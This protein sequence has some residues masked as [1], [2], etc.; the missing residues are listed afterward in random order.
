MT[1]AVL[2]CPTTKLSLA[3]VPLAAARAAIGVETLASRPP[4]EGFNATPFGET[5]TVLLRS[6]N[7]AAY[8]VL[9]D[10]IPVLFAPEVL[11]RSDS[12]PSFDLRDVRYAEAYEEMDHYNAIGQKLARLVADGQM[13]AL[14]SQDGFGL[15]QLG[16]IP[17]RMAGIAKGQKFP[18]PFNT[19][20]A[21][22]ADVA[23]EIDCY[24]H[25]A[26]VEGKRILQ[27]GGAAD[28]ILRLLLAGARDGVLLTPMVGEALVSMEL[29][30]I[31]G[32]SDRLQCVI[33]VGEELPFADEALDSAISAACVHHMDT[34]LAFPEINRVLRRG[35]K[36]AA[37][38]PWL[39]P[40]HNI[41]TAILGKREHGVHCR[42]MDRKRVAPLYTAFGYGKAVLHG[43]F[44]RYAM[45]VWNDKLGLP[46]SLDWAVR[47]SKFD[48]AVSSFVPGMR[49]LGSGVAMIA[50]KSS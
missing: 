12:L 4:Q 20:V 28:T 3:Y 46:L 48:D 10:C 32:L 11:G 9:N 40:L 50:T 27:I 13:A 44:V 18:R 49:K 15:K 35:G 24:E 21:S 41:G 5:S 36:F 2:V 43:A 42:P 23:S 30:K 6:D 25:L 34:R 8:P 22:R 31:F 14:E 19:W 17:D 16:R 38:D 45:I 1:N 33:G 47:L 26:P 39:A 29:A 37:F 7:K